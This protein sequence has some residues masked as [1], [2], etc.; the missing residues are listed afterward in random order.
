M[1]ELTFHSDDG[2]PLRRKGSSFRPTP[3]DASWVR[4]TQTPSSIT[5]RPST[6]RYDE[7]RR[8]KL[9]SFEHDRKREIE[10]THYARR[11]V[12]ISRVAGET[13]SCGERRSGGGGREGGGAAVAP[14]TDGRT[15]GRTQRGIARH[16]SVRRWELGRARSPI[17][18]SDEGEGWKTRTL[19]RPLFLF[20]I[21]D[22]PKNLTDYRG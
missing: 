12:P 20:P 10:G 11:T 5:L 1:N 13:L 2:G 6:T 17:A 9:F 15:D 21:I 19:A 8:E 18:R 4:C 14:A 7:N 22:Q 16:P 3:R